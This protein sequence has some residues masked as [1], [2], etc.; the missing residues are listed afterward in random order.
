MEA[1]SIYSLYNDA[2]CAGRL[3][4]IKCLN[5]LKNWTV[6]LITNTLIEKVAKYIPPYLHCASTDDK[7]HHFKAASTTV[8]S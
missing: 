6:K 1:Y 5:S 4:E 7:R 8:S 3:R 2:L